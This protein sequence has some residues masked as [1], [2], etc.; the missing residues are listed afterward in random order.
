[1]KDN[2]YPFTV[3]LVSCVLGGPLNLGVDPKEPALL[4][5]GGYG[6]G[7]TA[8]SL[9]GSGAGEESAPSHPVD[10]P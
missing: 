10:T 2:S 6:G 1:M 3:I 5:G 9:E 4:T 7:E 8:F